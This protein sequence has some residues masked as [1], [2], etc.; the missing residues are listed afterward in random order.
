MALTPHPVRVRMYQR[1]AGFVVSHERRRP[2][3]VRGRWKVLEIPASVGRY[4][5]P[6]AAVVRV[7]RR[8]EYVYHFTLPSNALRI[9]KSGT[10]YPGSDARQLENFRHGLGGRGVGVSL[11]ELPGF[12]RKFRYEKG[13]STDEDVVG[14]RLRLADYPEI[15][16]VTYTPERFHVSDTGVLNENVEPSSYANEREWRLKG[17]V[18]LQPG[19]FDVFKVGRGGKLREA[20]W[21]VDYAKTTSS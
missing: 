14:I 16:P 8:P 4:R 1:G 17:P 7:G 20:N 19:K 5:S 2:Y 13:V 21:M 9:L 11:T 12:G 10:I 6:G 3:P 18:R 15:R